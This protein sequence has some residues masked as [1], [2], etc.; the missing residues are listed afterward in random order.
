[1]VPYRTAREAIGD[2]LPGTPEPGEVAEGTYADLLAEVPPGHNYL[3]HTE[4]YGGRAVF[5][6]RSR[7]WTFL[8]RLDPGR[9]STTLQAQPGP[10]GGGHSTG[11]T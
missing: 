7:Y 11:R 2:L 3:W 1:M 4:R 8:L 10:W 9:P 6:W 5:T